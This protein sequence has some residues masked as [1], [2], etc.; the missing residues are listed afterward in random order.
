MRRTGFETQKSGL[1]H[2]GVM[3]RERQKT[4]RG[5]SESVPEFRLTRYELELLDILWT[6]GEGTVQDVHAKLERPLAYTSVMTTLNLLAV[7][8]NVVSREKRGRAFWYRPLISRDEASLSLLAEFGDVLFGKHA[9]SVV[10]N[11]LAESVESDREAEILREAL[12][13]LEGEG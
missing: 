9:P 3:E 11:F 8:K 12:E 5:K 4:S 2:S 13:K 6:L 1:R 10:L 7:K